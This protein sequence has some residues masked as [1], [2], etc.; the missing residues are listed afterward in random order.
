M[1]GFSLADHA[2]GEFAALIELFSRACDAFTQLLVRSD[3]I[4][5]E[6]DFTGSLHQ[7]GFEAGRVSALGQ[8]LT[9][10][11]GD[12]AWTARADTVL[13]EYMAATLLPEEAN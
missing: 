7:M 3:D 4:A 1:S 5:D 6:V 9:I 11:T 8:A 12:P 10:L 13:A 2:N